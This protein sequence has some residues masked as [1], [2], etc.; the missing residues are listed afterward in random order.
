ME[1]IVELGDLLL[2]KLRA[3]IND[4]PMKNPESTDD[5]LPLQLLHT[6]L[7]DAC[8]CFCLHPF[9][10]IFACHYNKLFYALAKGKYPKISSPHRAK[11]HGA[12][13]LEIFSRGCCGVR[14]NL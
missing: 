12:T 10:E 7:S 5:V 6:S 14:V 8:N 2:L 1:V 9:G 4:D 3:I 13:M 11:R